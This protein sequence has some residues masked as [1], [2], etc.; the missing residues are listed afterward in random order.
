L[1]KALPG[2]SAHSLPHSSP[3]SLAHSSPRTSSYSWPRS[4]SRL[5]GLA[6]LCVLLLGGCTWDHREPLAPQDT[7]TSAHSLERIQIDPSHMP[8]PELAAHRFDP[9]DGLDIDEVAILAVANNPSVRVGEALKLADMKLGQFQILAPDGHLFALRRMVDQMSLTG[10]SEI[11]RDNLK[12]MLVVT[13]RIDGRDL[14]ST[15]TDARNPLGERS[16][17]PS[18]MHDELG[19]LYQQQ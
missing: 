19:G 11:S 2:P 8:L 3:P 4:P 18:G 6:A 7:S 15:I 9:T 12:R 5:R 14:G 17:L 13:A 10:Q 16:L 1:A